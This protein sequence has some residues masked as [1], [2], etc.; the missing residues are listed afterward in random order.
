MR[1]S[2]YDYE[3]SALIEMSD[4]ELMEFFLT[5]IF[6]TEEVWGL[7]DSVEWALREDE[8]QETLPVWPYKNLAQEAAVGPWTNYSPMDSSL[9]DFIMNTLPSMIEDEVMIEI[10]PRQDRKG[11]IVSPHRLLSILEGMMD[12]GEYTLDG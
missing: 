12:A 3:Y 9:E 11:C 8:E 1:Y 4:A 2:P 10:I 7:D 6:E 5:R